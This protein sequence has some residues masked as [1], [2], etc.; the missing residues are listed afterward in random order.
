MHIRQENGIR[1]KLLITNNRKLFR[2]KK[3]KLSLDFYLYFTSFAALHSHEYKKKNSP[4]IP[5]SLFLREILHFFLR[6][7]FFSLH[8]QNVK[9]S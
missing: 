1:A 3:M 5:I 4:A 2:L 9:L 7:T 8:K 6:Y